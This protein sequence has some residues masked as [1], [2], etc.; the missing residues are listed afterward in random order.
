MLN[1]N[2]KKM[3][4]DLINDGILVFEVNEEKNNSDVMS[5]L[6]L[7]NLDELKDFVK[8][9]FDSEYIKTYD[10]NLSEDNLNGKSPKLLTLNTQKIFEGNSMNDIP[11]YSKTKEWF[12]K[13]KDIV[14]NHLDKALFMSHLENE[15]YIDATKFMIYNENKITKCIDNTAVIVT[16]ALRANIQAIT[17]ANLSIFK[18]C[19]YEIIGRINDLPEEFHYGK[20]IY[21]FSRYYEIASQSN[22]RIFKGINRNDN[23]ICG[24]GKK[25]KKCCMI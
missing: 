24:S 17:E 12:N 23:C 18:S 2:Y 3:I 21:K 14:N 7:K 8:K 1:N 25:F 10:N 11:E 16:P 19:Y 22:S 15:G 20:D 9:A 13:N 5:V 6:K 4:L